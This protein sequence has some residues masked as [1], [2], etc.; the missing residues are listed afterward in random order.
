MK[1]N[2]KPI[3]TLLKPIKNLLSYK[4]VVSIGIHPE[5]PVPSP[6]AVRVCG[7]SP[8]AG[9]VPRCVTACTNIE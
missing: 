8:K 1:N 3:K 4:Y 7:T 2:E 5:E 9:P 6:K